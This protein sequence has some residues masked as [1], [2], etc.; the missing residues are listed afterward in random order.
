MRWRSAR[1]A[2]NEV[3]CSG[4]GGWGFLDYRPT[5]TAR[6]NESYGALADRIRQRP[7]PS[8]LAVEQRQETGT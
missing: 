6:G 5:A 7:W 4:R 1:S 2:G 3:G 8:R